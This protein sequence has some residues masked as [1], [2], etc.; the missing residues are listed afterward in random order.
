MQKIVEVMETWGYSGDCLIEMLHDI[1][2]EYNHL[3][4][5]AMRLL[6]A[7]LNIPLATITHVATFYDALSIDAAGLGKYWIKVCKGTPCYVK[8]APLVLESLE[9]ELLIKE[10]E[11]TGDQMFTL[12]ST[13]CL[14]TCGIAPVLIVN[15]DE[16][17][18]YL[19]VD[20]MGRF[21]KQFREREN[22]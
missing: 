17:F 16:V 22:D 5:N 2:S 19:K 7:R 12:T 18:G 8:G 21:I 9:R 6:S 15:D 1:Q 14:G 11:T 3:P 13:R 10:G 20:R 4:E